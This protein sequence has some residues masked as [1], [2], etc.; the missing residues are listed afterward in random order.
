MRYYTTTS[1]TTDL[2]AILPTIALPF[3]IRSG[4]VQV[5]LHNPQSVEITTVFRVVV[6][7]PSGTATSSA[8]TSDNT[9]TIPANT[10]VRADLGYIAFAPSSSLTHYRSYL[11]TV[12]VVRRRSQESSN[13]NSVIC[14][15]VA[16]VPQRT[17]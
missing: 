3:G 13:S 1:A 10:T 4:R 12:A 15:G 17:A 14:L 7:T 5:Y 9:I 11:L 8:N 2:P 6:R 16:L